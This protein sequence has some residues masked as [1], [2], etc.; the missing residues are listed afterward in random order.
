MPP[1][2]D[3]FTATEWVVFLSVGI[4]SIALGILWLVYLPG[5]TSRAVG[6]MGR[7]LANRRLSSLVLSAATGLGWCLR[8]L[9]IAFTVV[10]FLLFA[11]ILVLAVSRAPVGLHY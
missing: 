8:F 2:Q 10:V 7:R 1:R 9:G 6:R 11:L 5:I 4:S 3:W